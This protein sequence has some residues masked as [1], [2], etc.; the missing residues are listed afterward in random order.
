[1]TRSSG[2]R[3]SEHAKLRW[4]QR[5]D[6]TAHPL[7]AGVAIRRFLKAG[8]ARPTPR[9]WLQTR[10]VPGTCFVFDANRPGVCVLVREGAAVTVL[11]RDTQPAVI[12]LASRDARQRRP[13]PSTPPFDRQAVYDDLAA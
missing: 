7:A 2:I 8:K 1:M 10:A 3:I 12:E 4:Q 5:V 9:H 11:T 6:A 13:V